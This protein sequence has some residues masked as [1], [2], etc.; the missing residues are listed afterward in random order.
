MC[1]RWRMPVSFLILVVALSVTPALSD[2]FGSQIQYFSQVAAG[3]GSVTSFSIHNPGAVAA[4]VRLELRS[5]DTEVFHD[6]SVTIPPLGTRTVSVGSGQSTLKVGWARL[7]AT[8]GKFAATEFF[9]LRVGS[10]DLPRVGV[11]PSIPAGSLRLF[12]FV[13]SQTN[14]GIAVSNPSETETATLNVRLLTVEG[15]ALLT[16][17]A[18]LAPRSHLASFLNESPWFPGLQN[19]EGVVELESNHPVISTMLRSDGAQL[20]AASVIVPSVSEV[21]A[22]GITTDFIADGAVSTPKIA[23][24]AVTGSKIADGSVTLAKLHPNLGGA[25][26][27]MADAVADLW[28]PSQATTI[29]LFP[30]VTNS[31]GFDTGISI[32]NTG[33]GPSGVI[34]TSGRVRLYYYGTLSNGSQPTRTQEIT[35]T[36]VP[37]G[38]MVKLILSTGG[39][40]GLQGNPNFEGYIIAVCDFPLAHGI[41]FITDGPIGIARISFGGQAL[42]LPSPRDPARVESRGN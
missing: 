15:T 29:L 35:N 34:G 19:F 41:Y 20:A 8:S 2:P 10:Q 36:S 14:S 24:G 30:Y 26:T 3:A 32:S 9:Q 1:D 6:S 21:T 11:L 37:A 23:D 7:T 39:S 13:N 16:S 25:L 27:A 12:G 31:S 33:L 40:Y 42:V 22:G 5:S 17:S 4:T 28:E 18:T 38:S